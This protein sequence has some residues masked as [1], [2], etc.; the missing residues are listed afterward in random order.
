MSRIQA[1]RARQVFDACGEPT[2]EAEVSTADGSFRAIAPSAPREG[3]FIG[4]AYAARE[5][6]DNDQ[7]RYGGRGV[8]KAVEAVSAEIADAIID[9]DP[10]DQE[11]IDQAMIDLDGSEDGKKG[12]LGSNTILAVSMA[13][14]R[15][16][17]AKKGIPLYKH[18][19]ALAGN[20][21]PLLPVPCFGLIRGGRLSSSAIAVEEFSIMP[22]AAETYHE[23]LQIGIEVYQTLKHII[24]KSYGRQAAAVNDDGAF[25]PPVRENEDA[26]K[27][28]VEAVKAAGFEAHVQIA[29]G[30]GA[31][32]FYDKEAGA[33]DLAFKR[34]G[35]AT[36]PG[37]IQKTE[38]DL[39][40]MYKLFAA[41]FVV[42]S[43]E[44]P[45]HQDDW[46]AYS[47]LTGEVGEVMQV[48]G[49]DLLCGNP[50]RIESAVE[51][52]ACNAVLLKID[53]VGTVSDAIQAHSLARNSGMG[54]VV[55]HRMGDTEDA[56]IA[57]LAVGLGTGQ[58]KAGAPCRS[59]RLSKYNQLVRIEEDMGDEAT[60]AG[61]Y[62]RDPWMI[63][64]SKPAKAYQ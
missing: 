45:F 29:V 40:R 10:T 54:V 19:N 56:F 62:W 22:T 60:F 14:C 39:S 57:D 46:S 37:S 41:N 3:L 64:P 9:M 17:A 20:P 43:V 8:Q 26:L 30:V 23:A 59:E 61:D 24:V 27:L 63:T 47:K 33:Y 34:K 52:N 16:G 1:V 35:G 5:L 6:R 21:V 25:S 36:S 48:V 4:G 51:R 11:G 32:E 58:I 53:Q 7:A 2:V 18:I 31:S 42:A 12:R 50:E 13:V 44:D 15:A 28:L 49:G 55:S 38:A